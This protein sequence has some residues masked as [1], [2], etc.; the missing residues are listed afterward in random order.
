MARRWKDVNEDEAGQRYNK[1]LSRGVD[2]LDTELPQFKIQDGDNCVRIIQ[3]LEDDEL[4]Q[5]PFGVQLYVHYLEGYGYLVSPRGKD[6]SA[7]DPVEDLV[8]E[9]RKI[10]PKLAED[11][12]STSR[13]VVMQI[14]DMNDDADHGELK[15][16][17]AP[18]SLCDDIMG[19]AKDKRTGNTY[20]IE[21][22][23]RGH[24]VYFER[25]GEGRKTRYTGI[26]LDREPYVLEEA[27]SEDLDYLSE[28]IQFKTEDDVREICEGFLASLSGGGGGGDGGGRS[29]R[30]GGRNRDDNEDTGRGRRPSSRREEP[31]DDGADHGDDPPP[32]SRR[33]GRRPAADEATG[34]PDLDNIREGV[35]AKLDAAKGAQEDPEPESGTS[36]RRRG[37]N[38]TEPEPEPEPEAAPRRG[39]RRRR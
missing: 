24:C 17:V 34:D 29:S 33:G 12:V 22:P 20:A 30:R 16:W 1:A 39:G 18:G 5:H 26:Q 11:S 37:F 36:G 27:L 9:L 35:Q 38:R 14:L 21:H 8:R 4:A 25:S 13:R 23:V 28:V 2:Y 19:A 32:R 10:D 6:Q 7:R 3:P 15:V 31:S